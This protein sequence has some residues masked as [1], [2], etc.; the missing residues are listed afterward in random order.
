MFFVEAKCHGVRAFGV[1]EV[2]MHCI[3]CFIPPPK[4]NYW[5]FKQITNIYS[6]AFRFQ[7]NLL[8]F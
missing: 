5:L 4:I 8:Y 7:S 1:R 6:N 2:L 3:Y